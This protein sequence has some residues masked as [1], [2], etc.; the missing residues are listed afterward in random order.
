M[1]PVRKRERGKKKSQ[2]RHTGQSHVDWET[3]TGPL[4]N[5]ETSPLLPLTLDATT[6]AL[7]PMGHTTTTHSCSRSKGTSTS[8]SDSISYRE[9]QRKNQLVTTL[10]KLWKNHSSRMK[11]EGFDLA[12]TATLRASEATCIARHPAL[13]H[14]SS[15]PLTN[16]HNRPSPSLSLASQLLAKLQTTA[17]HSQVS[18]GH[19]CT[20]VPAPAL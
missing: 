19:L 9:I 14:Q 4:P 2:A 1:C 16:L 5:G 8:H 12:S 17:R 11:Q 20:L 13:Q 3:S 10:L 18:L 15:L 6:S 7:F